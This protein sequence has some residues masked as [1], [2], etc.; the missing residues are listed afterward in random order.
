MNNIIFLTGN[1][2]K[3]KCGVCDYTFR[4]YEK[5]K[6]ESQFSLQMVNVKDF[7]LKMLLKTDLIIINYPCPDYGRSILPLFYVIIARLLGKKII[8]VMHELTYVKFLRKTVIKSFLIFASR[9]VSVTNEEIK[10]LPMKLR[11]KAK[12]IPI[13]SNI[14]PKEGIDSIKGYTV[15]TYFGVFYP[16]KEIERIIR[17]AYLYKKNNRNFKIRLIGA[18]HP[19]HSDYIDSLKKMITKYKLKN[20]I[21]WYIDCPEYKVANLLNSTDIALLF[22]NEGV[23]LRR[24]SFLTSLENC[25]PVITNKGVDTPDSLL[26]YESIIFAESDKNIAL[27]MENVSNNLSHYKKVALKTKKSLG[28]FTWNEISESYIKLIN[29]VN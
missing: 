20:E 24:G 6:S 1:I 13:A 18:R 19:N 2:K 11:K 26:D 4:L 3:G 17:A 5:L 8:Y 15:F 29:E 12:Y 14:T 25:I 21:E 7:R 23:T 27:Q 22:Y 16:A 10:R 28:L 9:I